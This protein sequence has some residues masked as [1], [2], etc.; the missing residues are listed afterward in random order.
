M[1]Q[2]QRSP[3]GSLVP[4]IEEQSAFL[5]NDLP[6][7]VD[8]TPSIIYLLD[9]ASRAV[10]ILSGI[11]ETIPNTH[12]LIRPFVRREAVLSSKIE[13]TQA[14][15]SD[16]YQFEASRERRPIRD[17]VEVINYL[18]AL[19]Q[20]IE[21]LNDIPISFRLINDV[22][23][24]LMRRVRGSDLRPGEIRTTQVWIGQQG[25]PIEEARYVPPPATY[26]RDLML[27]LER[28]V[29]DDIEMPPLI[30]CAL[31]HY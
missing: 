11:G 6:R 12:L 15:I 20:G 4:T 30:Q 3:S 1:N 17:A 25:S 21:R 2:L 31:M 24:I 8:L 28:F 16:L 27:D 26:I 19:E 7:H 13:G 29:N 18:H 9:K 5:P 14:S 23:E 10:S 22:H